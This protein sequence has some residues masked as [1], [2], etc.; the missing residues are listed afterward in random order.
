[1]KLAMVFPGQGSQSVGMLAAYDAYP[2][3]RETLAEAGADLEQDLWTLAA[4]GPGEQLNQTVNTQPLMLA[5]DV[6]VYRAWLGA[7][8]VAPAVVAGHSLGEYAALVAAGALQLADALPLVRYR[9]QAMQDA[10]PAGVGAM[11]AIMGLDDA[12]IAAA[13]ADA[14]QGQV[15]EPV[16]FN[17]PGQIVIAG[18]REAV[19]RA[20]VAAKAKGAKRGVLLPVSAPFH[21]SLLRP[22]AERLS[23]Y[24][25]DVIVTTPIIPVIH[26]VDAGMA[27]DAASIRA[28][29]A[30]QAASPVRWVETVQAFVAA[31]V[32]HVFEC[33]PGQVLTGLCKRIAPDLNAM[34]M[35][36][37]AAIEAALAASRA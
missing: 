1:M 37:G 33:G 5:A 6:A 8:G 4:E 11:A 19:E 9:A 26:N 36:D 21:S 30:K 31:G 14:A 7:G 12:G 18:H 28:A 10:V 2:V 34:P 16:N 35:N 15:V 32:T 27:R 29:L 22:A 25:A 3:V 20:I 17:A 13:C 23:A 24:L